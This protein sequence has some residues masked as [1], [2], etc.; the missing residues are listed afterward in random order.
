MEPVT[1][2]IELARRVRQLQ[3]AITALS[4]MVVEYHDPEFDACDS[5]RDQVLEIIDENNVSGGIGLLAGFVRWHAEHH[6]IP[7]ALQDLAPDDA[8]MLAM[9]EPGALLPMSIT[10]EDIY[11]ITGKRWDI[12][13]Y[14]AKQRVTFK[15]REHPHP[16]Y[17]MDM[18]SFIDRV[19][20]LGDAFEAFTL[21]NS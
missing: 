21:S 12:F 15:K 17:H 9:A 4:S 1:V 16:Q 14:W 7:C 10:L 8:E 5:V 18:A 13:I 2:N 20:D 19:E 3:L 6:E 11:V